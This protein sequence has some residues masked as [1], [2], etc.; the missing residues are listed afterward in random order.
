MVIVEDI[1]KRINQG[2]SGK[3]AALHAGKTLGT[4]MLIAS[5]T[6]ILAFAPPMFTDNITAIYMQTL[7]IVIGIMLIIS[8]FVAIMLVPIL[9]Q[10]SV[11]KGKKHLSKV[12]S[13]A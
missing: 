5:L 11:G 10:W 8:W 12:S 4:P 6:V 7:T 9:A 1:S 13:R 3:S 2:E